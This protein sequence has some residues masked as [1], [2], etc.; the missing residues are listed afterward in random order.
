MKMKK[1]S[2]M[3]SEESYEMLSELGRVRSIKHSALIE[4]L[5]RLS[6]KK[7]TKKLIESQDNG[8]MD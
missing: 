7:Y 3:I 6:Y 8:Q 4:R 5:I 1:T 2:I